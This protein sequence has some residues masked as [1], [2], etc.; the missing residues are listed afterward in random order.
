MAEDQKFYL[1]RYKLEE[2]DYNEWSDININNRIK[3]DSYNSGN[4][5]NLKN[6]KIYL[7]K[8]LRGN[9]VMYFLYLGIKDVHKIIQL[10]FKYHKISI[11]TNFWGLKFN[12]F[13]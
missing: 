1:G 13:K 9:I 3:I 4:C 5:S 2:C 7:F 11:I 10:I 6:Y 12:Y 8:M